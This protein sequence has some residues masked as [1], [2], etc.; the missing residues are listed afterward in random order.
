MCIPRFDSPSIFGTL[1]DRRAGS[2]RVGPY[3]TV[4]P[5]SVR[6]V[7]GTMI[8]ETTW[9]TPSGWIV[10][11]DGLTI[12][13]W[14]DDH[15]DETSHTRPPTDQ[16]RRSHDGPPH[17][18]HSG[19]GSGRGRVR[20]DVRLRAHAGAVGD[21][22]GGLV[23]RGGERRGDRAETDQ[24]PAHRDRGQPGAR[25][26]HAD[27]GRGAVRRARVAARPERPRPLRQRQ[28]PPP[29]HVPL[30]ARLARRRSLP[31]PSVAPAPAALGAD[32][33]GPDVRADRLD[34]RRR[35]HVAPRDARRRAQLGL[36]VLL[37]AR[38]DVHAVGA[39]RDRPRLGG[40]RLH[41]VRRRP[42]AQWGRRAPDHV[43]ARRRARPPRAGAVP[44]QGLRGR[45]A[46]QDRKRRLQAAP[47]R[48]VRR[49]ARLGV[50][51]HARRRPHPPA[52]VARAPGPGPLCARR[53]AP[54]R[55]GHLGGAR[56]A[57][58][59][60]LVEA[61]VLGRGGSGRAAGRARGRGG[62]RV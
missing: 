35:H 5:L 41:A 48:R 53:L 32:A 14:H 3:G 21:R 10:V 56:R 47:E 51:A 11:H 39:P 18:V 61:H 38:R 27:R 36:P 30:L 9:M 50:P 16:R 44:P 15:A 49:R 60:R 26:A 45:L 19:H 1:L 55:S 46:G 12:G 2:F 24:R 52:T 22:R 29:D 33:E 20:A 59:L 58:A 43:R 37:D 34:G 54:A 23:G 13:P 40:R 42:W 62:A 6:Y 31:G 57:Q 17:R 8:I 28:T 4:V 7:P 25:P